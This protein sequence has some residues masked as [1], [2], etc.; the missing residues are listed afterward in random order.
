MRQRFSLGAFIAS[1][2]LLHL[3]TVSADAQFILSNGT[4][5]G[6]LTVGVDGFGSFGSAVGGGTSDAIYNPFG[7]IEAAGTTFE[8]GLFLSGP[9]TWLTS[10]SIGGSQSLL[11]PEITGDSTSANSSFTQGALSF[12]LEQQLVD[13]FDDGG[14]RVGT[15]LNQQY[16]ITN[17]INVPNSFTLTRYLDGDLLF[18]GTISDGGGVIERGGNFIAFETDAADGDAASSTFVGITSSVG[19]TSGGADS[20]FEIAPFSTLR[21]QISQGNIL[22]NTVAQDLDFDGFIDTAFDVTLGIS[23][24]ISLD[25]NETVTYTTQTLFGNAVP[26]AP[27]S[28]E[29]LPLL[30]A[31]NESPFI[32][33]IEIEDPVERIWFDP[34]VTTGYLYDVDGVNVTSVTLPSELT[35]AQLGQYQ[36][37][38]F[39]GIDFELAALLDPGETFDFAALGVDRFRITNIDTGL[40][41][42]PADPAAFPI[43]LT[44]ANTGQ[45]QLSITPL[46]NAI[47]EPSSSVLIA[48]LVLMVGI[49]RRRNS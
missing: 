33:N 18:D 40:Q 28:S 38:L 8:S 12:S 5:D 45:V 25:A 13:S 31:S 46:T 26:P 44:F 29:A 23:D 37:E 7:S 22:G 11:N 3:V 43:G 49:R 48:S 35:V 6:S 20:R 36:L 14:N 32:F 39:N 41:L 2:V 21:E 16:R 9:P 24:F 10:G 30:P 17:T 1:V 4:G 19:L 15:V 47:P 34:E 42:D 27:G